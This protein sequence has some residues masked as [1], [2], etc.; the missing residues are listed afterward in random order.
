[1][2]HSLRIEVDQSGKIETPHRT[3]LAFSN[4]QQYAVIIPTRVKREVI[5]RLRARGLSRSLAAIRL[6]AA[7]LW[8]LLRDVIDTATEI[9][10]DTEYIGHEADIKAAL[11]RLAWRRGG[12]I[13]AHTIVFNAIGKKSGAHKRAIGVY[14]G[15]LSADRVITVGDLLAVLGK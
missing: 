13:E 8:L 1:M 14:R 4:G 11:L 6:F 10:I 3:V 12:K 5:G 7:A 9:A 2:T 15:E